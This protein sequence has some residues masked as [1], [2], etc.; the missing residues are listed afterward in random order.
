MPVLEQKTFYHPFGPDFS[1]RLFSGQLARLYRGYPHKNGRHPIRFLC[2]GSDRVTGDSL[3]PL[4]GYKLKKYLPD[5][6]VIGT[7]AKPVHA[8][9]LASVLDALDR[10]AAFVVAIDASLGDPEHIGCITLTGGSIRPGLGVCK[11]LPSVG[12]ASV[13]GIV[14]SIYSPGDCALQSTRLSLVMELADSIT[15]GILRFYCLCTPQSLR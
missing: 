2:I 7:L 10:E 3:G 1:P 6:A 15:L 14:G 11:H 13:T 9:N 4:I 12:H 8:L 5:D